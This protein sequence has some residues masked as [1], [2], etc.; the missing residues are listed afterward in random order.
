MSGVAGEYSTLL[1]ACRELL[2]SHPESVHIRTQVE[3]L[4]AAMPDSPGV[5]VS[6]CRTIIETTCKTIL[7]DRGVEVEGAWEAPKLVS[8]ALK[9]L[10][11]GR[12]AD[13]TFDTAV[14]NGSQSVVR[15]LNQIVQG[16]VEI[17]NSHGQAAHGADAY[18]PVL[19]VGYAEILARATDAIVGLLLRTHLNSLKPDT[20]MR[21]R[22]R[23]HPDFDELLDST[24]GPFE[25]LEVPILASEALFKTDFEAYRLGL[26]QYKQEQDED[27]AHEQAEEQVENSSS[28]PKE[29]SEP[30]CT[31]GDSDG[32]R[33]ELNESSGVP[34]LNEPSIPSPLTGDKLPEQETP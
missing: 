7:K 8:E 17:R 25:V 21:F 16:I 26:I 9:Y 2:A 34:P 29:G 14:G 4:E 31:S 33:D 30:E 6:F 10:E 24:Y 3:A 27:A 19:D 11:L 5:A 1:P 28:D 23:D 20:M 22:Y 32:S 13:G 18:A 15:G 12:T